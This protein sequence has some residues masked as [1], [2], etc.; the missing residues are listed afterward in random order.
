MTE[1]KNGGKKCLP[2]KLLLLAEHLLPWKEMGI[3]GMGQKDH[4]T[5]TTRKNKTQWK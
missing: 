4:C 2:I 3:Y 5:G 1:K